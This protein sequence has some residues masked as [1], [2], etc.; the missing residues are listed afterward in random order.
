V[1]I[2][3]IIKHPTADDTAHMHELFRTVIV[4]TFESEGIGHLQE[5][6][7]QEIHQKETYWQEYVNGGARSF[8]V[9]TK[10]AKVIGCIEY[11]KAGE[12]VSTHTNG[13]LAHLDKVGTVFVHPGHQGQGIGSQLVQAM[14][15]LM[16][17]RG[18]HE[19]CLDSGYK[20]AQQVWQQKFGEPTYV[21]TD[22]WDEGYH[23]MIW[24]REVKACL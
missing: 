20:R 2:W 3:I 15:R 21:L 13:A 23:H 9:A 18:I 19:F 7:A 24:R 11:G 17:E 10:G 5:D 16:K 12:F 1:S 6:L 8:L 22:F 4:H 14:L